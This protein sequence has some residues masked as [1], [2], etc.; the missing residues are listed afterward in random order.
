MVMKDLEPSP[1]LE[2]RGLTK[3]F[4]VGTFMKSRQ[5]HAV[6]NVSFAVQPGQVVALVGK[7]GSGKT[8]TIRLIARLIPATKGEIYFG[9]EEVLKTEPRQSSLEYRRRVQMIFQDPFASLNAVHTDRASPGAPINYSQENGG[10]RGA[11][12][13]SVPAA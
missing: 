13:T 11:V 8:T 3:H 1:I 7:S 2:V 4:S 9:G 6:E 12:R 10:A 5:V